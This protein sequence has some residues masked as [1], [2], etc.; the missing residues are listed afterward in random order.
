MNFIFQISGVGEHESNCYLV[1]YSPADKYF[2]LMKL[3]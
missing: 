3:C 2:I 1:P